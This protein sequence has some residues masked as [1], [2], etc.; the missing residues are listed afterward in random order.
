MA[1]R[2]ADFHSMAVEILT[3]TKL[4]IIISTQEYNLSADMV[5]WRKFSTQVV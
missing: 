4:Q 5:L 2:L 3:S 1:A